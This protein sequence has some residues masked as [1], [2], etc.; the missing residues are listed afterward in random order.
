[1]QIGYNAGGRLA[2]PHGRTED[3]TDARPT[4]RCRRR[5]F[6]DPFTRRHRGRRRAHPQ[7]AAEPQQ[8]LRSDARGARRCAHRHRARRFSARGR[9]GRQRTGVFRRPRPQG[10][11]P[12][13][14]R[15]RPRPRLFQACHDHVQRRHAAD[16]AVAATGD[17]GG[18]GDGH[19]GRLPIGGK[20]R[21][22]G[23][24]TGRQVR[25]ARRQY[26]PV[27][28]D[29]DGCAVAQ[30]IAQA[31]HG[32]AAH[33]RHDLGRRRPTHRSRQRRGRRRQRA[34]RRDQAREKNRR[35]IELD[36]QDRQGS[37]LSAARNAARRGLQIYVGSHGRKHAGARR[38]GA[39]ALSSRNAS[40]IGRTADLRRA[41]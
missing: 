8:P 40:R 13:P 18:A 6:A 9:A 22:R 5:L 29:A 2:N 38:R 15:R 19:G 37:V 11:Q 30:R 33:R 32:D 1:M 21:S 28:L 23:R 16:R 41:R 20:L 34:R 31:C 3:R 24:L 26:R 14:F 17:R 10:A 39:S 27:L 36:R 4:C 25:D 12:A 7:P 35:Q